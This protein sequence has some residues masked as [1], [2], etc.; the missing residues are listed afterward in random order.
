MVESLGAV[1]KEGARP[2]SRFTSPRWERRLKK[3]VLESP[4]V[5]GRRSVADSFDEDG[6][7]ST[8]SIATEN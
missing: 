1:T 8:C 2:E 5:F 6:D 7:L 3:G 4:D